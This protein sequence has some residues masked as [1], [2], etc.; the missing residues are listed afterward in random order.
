MDSS[1]DVQKIGMLLLKA[2]SMIFTII[3]EHSMSHDF[4]H[5]KTKTNVFI[6]MHLA[7]GRGDNIFYR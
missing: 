3:S 2:G 5:H 6:S 1:V 7:G 4:C